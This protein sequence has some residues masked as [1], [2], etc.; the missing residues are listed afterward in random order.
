MFVTKCGMAFII[1]GL[2]VEKAE[3]CSLTCA[4]SLSDLR[5]KPSCAASLLKALTVSGSR[6]P[7]YPQ[8]WS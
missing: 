6:G 8:P 3:N 4:D 5:S 1:S 2:Q 7:V